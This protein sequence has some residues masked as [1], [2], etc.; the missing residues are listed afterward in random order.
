MNLY[1]ILYTIERKNGDHKVKVMYGPDSYEN[2]YTQFKQWE[3]YSGY[4]MYRL[5][6]H[7][8]KEN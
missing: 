8:P 7:E 6:K 1:L 5:V 3:Q 2:V 4:S